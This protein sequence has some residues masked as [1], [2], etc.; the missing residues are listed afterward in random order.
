VWYANESG[1]FLVEAPTISATPNN[2]VGEC[3]ATISFLVKFQV[4]SGSGT[5]VYRFKGSDGRFW[6]QREL[7]FDGPGAKYVNWYWRV[8][9][10][11]KKAHETVEVIEPADIKEQKAT[12]SVKC[13]TTAPP[14]P[15]PTAAA[16]P[17]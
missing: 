15:A 4:S 11:L 3:P 13:T 14:S 7:A 6:P 12:F 2:Y 9:E 5:I 10:D 8:S 17:P 16:T 1:K